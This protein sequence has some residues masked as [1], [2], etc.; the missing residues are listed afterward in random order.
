MARPPKIRSVAEY[1]AGIERSGAIRDLIATEGISTTDLCY[2]ANASY[3]S[4]STWL[5][6]GVTPEQYVRLLNAIKAAKEGR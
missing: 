6:Q 5:R 3:Q 1:A 4:V 2:H